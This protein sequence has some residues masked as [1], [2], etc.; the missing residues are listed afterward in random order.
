MGIF[1][2]YSVHS[3]K[4][5]EEGPKVY[6]LGKVTTV[7]R[8]EMMVVCH[9]HL[10]SM[11]S[12]KLRVVWTPAYLDADGL[13]STVPSARPVME[14]VEVGRII[15]PCVLNHGVVNHATTRKLDT[16]K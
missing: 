1:I 16:S 7:G 9:K 12:Y 15:T 5:P 13:E 6:R 8:S 4:R 11:Q 10:P 14:R 3:D 2:A